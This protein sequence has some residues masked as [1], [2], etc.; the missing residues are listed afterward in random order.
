MR[1]TGFLPWSAR[2]RSRILRRTDCVDAFNVGKTKYDTTSASMLPGIVRS[3]A[4]SFV[5]AFMPSSAAAYWRMKSSDQ[6]VPVRY[7][8]KPALRKRTRRL[9]FSRSRFHESV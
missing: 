2:K 3:A 7:T 8:E 1:A 4:I 5:V 9:P 6:G